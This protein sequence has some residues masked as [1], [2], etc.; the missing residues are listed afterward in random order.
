M[1]RRVA[2]AKEMHKIRPTREQVDGAIRQA[3]LS[4][5]ENERAAFIAAMTSVLNY[6]AI[7]RISVDA[8]AEVFTVKELE[9][10]VEYYSKPEA[11][12]ASKK[13]K[14]WAKIVQPEINRIIDKAMMRVRT[15]AVK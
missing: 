10:M 5:P 6:R 9:S 15:G 4:V 7:E 2:L 1:A 3:S 14:D 13:I 11:K 8:M 12:S